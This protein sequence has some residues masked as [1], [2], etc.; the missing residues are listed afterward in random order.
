MKILTFL[1]S[2]FYALVFFLICP[3]RNVHSSLKLYHS[4]KNPNT[5]INNNKSKIPKKFSKKKKKTEKSHCKIIDLEKE[6]LIPQFSFKIEEDIP[7]LKTYIIHEKISLKFRNICLHGK[8]KIYN[9]PIFQII[10]QARLKH[11][12]STLKLRFYVF[13]MAKHTELSSIKLFLK[14]N[15]GFYLKH[16]YIYDSYKNL[17]SK[18]H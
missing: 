9:S 11:D 4:E 8:G 12:L 16:E 15:P 14:K 2:Q 6:A 10:F 17:R 5:K 1:I 18:R 3:K 13:N 7:S